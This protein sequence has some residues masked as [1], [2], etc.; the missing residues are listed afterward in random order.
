MP[1][2]VFFDTN[3]LVYAHDEESPD[4]KAKSQKLIFESLREGA[5]VV[6]AQVLSEF[7]VTVTQKIA[8]PMP[9]I[10]AKREIV[11]LSTM[12]T[13]DIDST[14]VI[15]AVDMQDRWPLNY[16][17]A[18]ILAAAERGGCRT[19]YSEDMSDGQTYGSVTVRNPFVRG[20]VE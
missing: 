2:K 14:L 9:T 10:R 20:R 4:K 11:L 8:R 3:I 1:D 19:V 12:A 6:S 7:F 18:L 15:R 17:D 5:G 13:V 16:W